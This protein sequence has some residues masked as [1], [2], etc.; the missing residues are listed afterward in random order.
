MKKKKKVSKESESVLT[1]KE[2]LQEVEVSEAQLELERIRKKLGHLTLKKPIKYWLD[3]GS[4]KLNGVLG[5]EKRGIPY[6]KIIELFGWESHGK[7]LLAL[8]LAALGQGD[9]A[10]VGWADFENSFDEP[11]AKIQ[12]LDPREVTLFRPEVGL[13]GGDKT[14]RLSTAQETCEEIE[15]WLARRAL[16]K[17]EGKRVVIVD[18]VTGMLVDDEAEAG[19]TNQNMRTKVALAAYL[20]SM[21]RR[22]TGLALVY[23]VIF[24]FINQ[25]RMS[26]GAWG[27]PETTTGGNALRY[28]ASIRCKVRRG[29]KGGKLIQAG[30]MVGMKGIIQNIK[31]KAGGGSVEGMSCGFKAKFL[32]D[33]WSFMSAESIKKEGGETSE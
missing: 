19:L 24:V 4:P 26:P 30:K 21:L 1:A 14:P 10:E 7:T 6:G 18:S 29:P 27:N 22:W 32:E 9:D 33:N 23:N 17:P 11:W 25:I 3:T 28:Y 2:T 13:F 31:N 16:K 8:L 12:G 20:S 15:M 5:S